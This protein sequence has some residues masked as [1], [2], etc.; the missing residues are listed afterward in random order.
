MSIVKQPQQLITQTEADLSATRAQLSAIK[1]YHSSL[2]DTVYW[3]LTALS[4]IVAL[5]AGFGWFANFRMYEND[6]TRLKDDLEAKIQAV[7]AQVGARLNEHEAQLLQQLDARQESS[8][9]RLFNELDFVR[10]DLVKSIEQSE[11]R[12]NKLDSMVSDLKSVSDTLIKKNK[13]TEALVREVEEHIWELKDIPI[14][15]LLTQSQ[16]LST[17]IDAESAE[18]VRSAMRRMRRTINER[19]LP[20]GHTL[21]STMIGYLED[22]LAVAAKTDSVLSAEVQA[23]VKKIPVDDEAE[24]A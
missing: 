17:A 16:A 15:I 20:G 5:L 23:L 10:K 11:T 18:A 7:L 19:I 9:T 24:T 22:D 21:S 2:L 6:K 1:E 4:T 13:E 8:A 3:S 12:D 14:N